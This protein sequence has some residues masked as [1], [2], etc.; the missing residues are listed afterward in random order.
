MEYNTW[1]QAK[2]RL[3][4]HE[5]EHRMVHRATILQVDEAGHL[6]Q[7]QLSQVPSLRLYTPVPPQ[8]LQVGL[9]SLSFGLL[10]PSL[11]FLL[12]TASVLVRLASEEG[13]V[14]EVP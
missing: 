3:P 13:L 1:R 4:I 9:A 8:H 7:G 14:V 6:Q 5:K 12:M 11:L 10:P 2:F